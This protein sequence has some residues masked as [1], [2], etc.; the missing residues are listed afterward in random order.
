MIVYYKGVGVGRPEI[1]TISV[2]SVI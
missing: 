2:H 1:V